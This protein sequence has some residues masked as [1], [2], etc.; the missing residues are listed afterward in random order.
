MIDNEIEY[1]NSLKEI[2]KLWSSKPGTP[3]G[4]RF[5]ELA[6]M[7]DEYEKK[8]YPTSKPSIYEAIKFR[9]E[10]RDFPGDSTLYKIF[11]IP[12]GI[13]ALIFLNVSDWVDNYKNRSNK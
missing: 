4:D 13:A 8:N 9:N 11:A 7:I 12:M 5:Q 6:K 10:Q 2:E 3:N 1:K